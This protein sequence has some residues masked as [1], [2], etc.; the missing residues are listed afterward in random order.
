VHIPPNTACI[1]EAIWRDY[2]YRGGISTDE[3]KA[4]EK[5]FNRATIALQRANRIGRWQPF[6]WIVSQ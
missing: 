1:D 3:A 5:A 6:V 2:C 4:R